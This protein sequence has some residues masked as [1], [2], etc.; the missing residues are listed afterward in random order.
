MKQAIS[1][2]LTSAN[3]PAAVGLQAGRLCDFGFVMLAKHQYVQAWERFN[4]VLGDE[5]NCV[6]AW[7]GRSLALRGMGQW[8]LAMVNVK[9]AESLVGAPHAHLLLLRA[10]L[11]M[12]LRRPHLAKQAC[13]AALKL[14]PALLRAHWLRLKLGLMGGFK[15]KQEIE[16]AGSAWAISVVDVTSGSARELIA[17]SL[18]A[19][20]VDVR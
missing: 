4:A 14:K 20:P 17:R 3:V 15:A 10:E 6:A 12:A 5:P 13:E 1:P 16:I 7:Y 18:E 19:V 11:L 2:F 8:A 9:Q